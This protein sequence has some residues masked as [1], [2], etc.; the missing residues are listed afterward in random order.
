MTL[1][2]RIFQIERV[3]RMTEKK[4]DNL[5]K[6]WYETKGD[7]YNRTE[8]V[9][10]QKLPNFVYTLSFN[11]Q[12][13]E[14]FLEKREN[15]SFN[16]KVYDFDSAFVEHVL[17]TY[18][19]STSNL[20][21]LLNGVKGCGKSVTAKMICQS[22]QEKGL[23]IVI[24]DQIVPGM[25]EFLSKISQPFVM[26][27]D[28]Y[29]KIFNIGLG[30]HGDIL[31][32]TLMDGMHTSKYPNVF[33]LTCN[34]L[35]INEN[36]INRPGRLRYL[37]QYKELS[38]D[39]VKIIIDD[40]L[41]KDLQHFKGEILHF[42]STLQLVTIDVVMTVVK[43][44]NIHRQSPEKFSSFLNLQQIRSIYNIYV[45]DEKQ[46]KV[47]YK[48]KVYV[49][50]VNDVN[51]K[52]LIVAGVSFGFI[53]SRDGEKIVVKDNLNTRKTYIFEEYMKNEV[54]EEK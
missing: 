16:H 39:L 4:S 37:K 34:N 32:L 35:H 43:E 21:I 2:K 27:V 36:L 45:Y 3:K 40:L 41:L 46:E 30:Q 13:Q 52:Q 48:Q 53:E 23:P 28:E 14:V 25:V 24:I 10:H 17:K 12:T 54:F 9:V 42:L 18:E 31:L 26:F 20:G 50:G 22:L 8:S 29:E 7:F 6:V 15:L 11:Q 5:G 33:V 47:L 51:K 19:H 1:T 38:L 49:D 44:V